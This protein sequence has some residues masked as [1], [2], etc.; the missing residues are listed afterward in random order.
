MNYLGQRS[1]GFV[2][3]N[4]SNYAHP[5]AVAG[6]KIA[7]QGNNGLVYRRPGR[8]VYMTLRDGLLDSFTDTGDVRP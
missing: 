5:H 6:S 8:T 1:G 7:P 4:S 3:T 2:F